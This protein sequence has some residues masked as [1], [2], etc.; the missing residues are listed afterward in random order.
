MLGSFLVETDPRFTNQR[1]WLN[2]DYLLSQL[3]LDAAGMQ[4]W[5]CAALRLLT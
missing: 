2:S 4:H 1:T 5:M 3:S